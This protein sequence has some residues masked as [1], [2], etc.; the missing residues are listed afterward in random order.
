VNDLCDEDS[1]LEMSKRDLEIK[2]FEPIILGLPREQLKE[3]A[4]LEAT[5][6]KE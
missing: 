3:E 4:C 1:I 6:D 5:Y 2:S